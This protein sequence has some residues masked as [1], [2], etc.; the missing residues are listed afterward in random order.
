MLL[1]Q[2]VL[3]STLVD[4]DATTTPW[5]EL[6]DTLLRNLRSAH[7]R[8][9]YAQSLR[10]FF[11]WVATPPAEVTTR[12]IIAYREVLQT[13]GKRAATVNRHLAA[14][15]ALYA[16]AFDEGLLTRN[17]AAGVKT[18]ETGREG[19]TPA[20]TREQV[21]AML[22]AID[23]TTLPGLRD[24]ALLL[25]LV[26]TGIRREEATRVEVNDLQQQQGHWTLRVTRKGGGPQLVKVP[27]D[28]YRALS[29]WLDAAALREGVLWRSLTRTGRGR[30]MVY[31]VGPALTTDGILKIVQHRARRGGIPVQISPHALRATFITLAL[32]GGAPL[33]KVQYAA[34]H[35]DPRTTERY[36][37]T[38]RNLDDHA[39]DYFN[40]EGV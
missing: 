12:Q 7:S 21:Q 37:R 27:A 40:L 18:L 5:I 10:A 26:R 14:I 28:V 3:T 8:R 4:H 33:H 15:R 30:A 1:D 6:A 23:R 32:D 2:P 38:K 39:S 25:L 34:G 35:A 31:Q 29:A 36:H 19:S 24:Y 22:H 16:A 17:P 20:L 9:A 13:N 11:A